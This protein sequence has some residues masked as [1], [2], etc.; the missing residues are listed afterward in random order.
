MTKNYL[1]KFKPLGAFY[2]GG[3]QTFGSDA[4]AN[5]FVKSNY[6]PQQ[7]GILGLLRYELLLQNGLLNVGKSK[8]LSPDAKDLIGETSFHLNGSNTLIDFKAIKALS[9][10]FILNGDNQNLLAAPFDVRFDN[11]YETYTLSQLPESKTNLKIQAV[12]LTYIKNEKIRHFSEKDGIK[13]QFINENKDL[14]QLHDIFIENQKIGIHKAGV[15]ESFYKQTKLLMKEEFAFAC[16]VTLDVPPD[17]NFGSNTIFMGGD[18]S[19]FEM[20]VEEVPKMKAPSF[21]ELVFNTSN[22]IKKLILTSHAYVN[23]SIYEHCVFAITEQQSFRFL[24]TTVADTDAY[25]NLSKDKSK[26][27][28]PFKSEQFNLLKAGSVFYY[29]DKQLQGL[30]NELNKH[31]QFKQIG[32]NY[33][34]TK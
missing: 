16:Y 25:Y 28:A 11:V 7:T 32:Y 27:S 34:Q 10:L 30:K 17:K 33:Y 20:I 24:Q 31:P 1:I 6:F 12:G 29:K 26:K 18:K 23:K 9:P 13:H 22:D 5:Y 14:F 15:D 21:N 3:E 8:K 4:E 2:F 19:A